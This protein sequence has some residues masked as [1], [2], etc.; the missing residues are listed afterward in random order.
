[1]SRMGGPSPHTCQ[2]IFL[3]PQGVSTRRA[4][5]STATVSACPTTVGGE[6]VLIMV[7]QH[8]KRIPGRRKRVVRLRSQGGSK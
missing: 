3:L 8:K 1:M 2:T 6:V 4:H 5:A 7:S